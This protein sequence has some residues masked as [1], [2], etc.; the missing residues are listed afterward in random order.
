MFA[1]YDPGVTPGPRDNGD[2]VLLTDDP[3]LV[4]RPL[5][6]AD[7]PAL[8]AVLQANHNHLSEQGDMFDQHLSVGDLTAKLSTKNRFDHWHL[9]VHDDR[10]V[11]R[12]DLV[13]LGTGQAVFGYWLAA[14]ATGRGLTTIAGRAVI[15]HA[16]TMGLAEI[17]A[18]VSLGNTAS[19]AVLGRLGFELI[20]TLS[21]RTRWRLALVDPAPPPEMV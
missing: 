21:D 16:R 13:D 1:S 8:H 7:A 11:G 4:L 5:T 2:V 9:L 17:Y 19:E 3:S 10:I 15:D 6:H 12:M 18:G 20:Q 14:D